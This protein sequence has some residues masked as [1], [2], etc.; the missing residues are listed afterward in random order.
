ML[1]ARSIQVYG[2]AHAPLDDDKRVY[3]A[4]MY[5]PN[6]NN[7]LSVSGRKQTRSVEN[8]GKQKNKCLFK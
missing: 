6:E 4:V 8:R 1:T 2:L 3:N 7:K 5:P